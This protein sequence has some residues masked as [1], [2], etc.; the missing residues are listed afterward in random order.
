MSSN[1]D[2]LNE[3]QRAAVTA[4]LGAVLV[5]AGAGSGKTR[6]LVHRIAWLI[7]TKAATPSSIFAVTFTN[8]AARE[9][10]ERIETL[11]GET[12][13]PNWIGTFHGLCHRLLRFHWQEAGLPQ[14]FHVLDGDDQVRQV[15]HIVRD[16]QLDDSKFVPKQVASWISTKKE[17]G[18]RSKNFEPNENNPYERTL[19]RIYAQYDQVC[20][21]GG[22]VDFSE[23][24]LRAYEL[25][26]DNQAILEQYQKRFQHFLVDEFQDT[27]A[28]QYSWLRLISG[29]SGNLFVVGDDDQSI[30]GWRGACVE[31]IQKFGKDYPNSKTFR[32]EQNYRSS[33]NILNAANHLIANNRSRM[34]KKLWTTGSAG[35]PLLHYTALTDMEEARFVVEQIESWISKS[36]HHPGDCAILYRSNAQSRLFEQELSRAGVHFRVYGG[37]RFYERSEIK[38]AVAYLRLL[39]F[40]DDDAAFE[41]IVNTPPRSIG[42]RTLEGLREFA[43]KNNVSLWQA[44]VQSLEKHQLAT[45]ATHT[46]F[47]F[48]QLI[49]DLEKG[50]SKLKLHDMVSYIVGRVGLVEYY[51]KEDRLTAEA[52][53]E[54]LAE[55]VNAAHEFIQRDPVPEFSLVRFLSELALNSEDANSSS[56][57]GSAVQLM[58]LHAAKGL[59][60]PLVFM[61]GMEEHLFPSFRSTELLERLEEERRLCYV[62][63]TRAQ[64][65]LVLTNAEQRRFHGTYQNAKPSRFLNEIPSNL[66]QEVGLRGTVIQPP[67]QTEAAMFTVGKIKGRIGTP[68]MLPAS[69]IGPLQVGQKVEH[70]RFGRG[71]ILEL[72]GSGP[73]SKALV[74]FESHGQKRLVLGY[75]RLQTLH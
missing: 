36:H 17:E 48:L 58:T 63:I 59:E 9:V 19:A 1:L 55:L 30:Y 27:N 64:T 11:C 69:A 33:A 24:L 71:T 44:A 47:G 21:K 54:N 5:L 42:E 56:G 16:L 72:E 51:K 68:T 45:R 3:A 32:L 73:S 62:G 65:R 25:L 57:E 74:D 4:P 43:Q 7:E 60:F 50:T 18:C 66:V 26:K 10:R 41:R 35:E 39:S 38:D 23:L 6:V 53:E 8:K 28:L 15:R 2:S 61:V 34:G 46:V 31:N 49:D 20:T 12:T 52:R 13:G 29:K 75:A 22:F 14:T 67:S 37:L 40:R 70:P